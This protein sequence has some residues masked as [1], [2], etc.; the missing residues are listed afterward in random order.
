MDISCQIVLPLV[1]TSS[2]SYK[3]SFIIGPNVAD[4]LQYIVIKTHVISSIFMCFTPYLL[5]A[6]VPNFHILKNC[7]VCIL[8]ASHTL[9]MLKDRKL[10]EKSKHVSLISLERIV[11][12]CFLDAIWLFAF[13][14]SSSQYCGRSALSNIFCLVILTL[15]TFR[16]YNKYCYVS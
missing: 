14:I 12:D 2:F 8:L 16:F 1:D 4:I 7:H 15:R 3:Y 9:E 10:L 6:G 11:L 5:Y 13:Q